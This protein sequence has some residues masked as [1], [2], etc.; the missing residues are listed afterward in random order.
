MGTLSKFIISLTLVFL[1][2][3]CSNTSQEMDYPV[4]KKDHVVDEIFGLTIEA[5]YG[6]LEDF[7]SEEAKAWVEEQNILTDQFLNNP[8]QKSIKRDL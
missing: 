1:S 3:A 4:T 8:Y 2:T 6:W 7:T 5:P